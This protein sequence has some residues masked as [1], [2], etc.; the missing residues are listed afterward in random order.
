MTKHRDDASTSMNVMEEQAQVHKEVVEASKVRISKKVHNEEATVDLSSRTEAVTVKR[1]PIDKYVD[2]AP[3]VRHE[4]DTMIVP[5][6]QEVA[7]VQKRL[8]LVE[9]VHITKATNIKKEEETIP[10]RRE[11]VTVERVTTE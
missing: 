1:V 11:E 4:G 2:E 8:L 5:V 10:L 9:E 7:V 6:V 3:S